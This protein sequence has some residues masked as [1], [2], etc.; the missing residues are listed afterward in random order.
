MP[1]IE[2]RIALSI[3][4]RHGEVSMIVTWHLWIHF[5]PSL[6]LHP[7]IMWY[8]LL[9]LH[10]IAMWRVLVVYGSTFLIV[11]WSIIVVLTINIQEISSSHMCLVILCVK[12]AG[13]LNSWTVI[14]SVI[15]TAWIHVSSWSCLHCL[16]AL[17]GWLLIHL[18]LLS[19]WIRRA[20]ICRLL[21]L[22]RCSVHSL[23]SV[24][25]LR[26][27]HGLLLIDVIIVWLPS[28]VLIL[29]SLEIGRSK[30]FWIT[31]DKRSLMCLVHYTFTFVLR[32]K[33]LKEFHFIF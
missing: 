11:H 6:R 1:W 21:L 8:V 14:I 2:I 9:S 15:L 20:S 19:D 13:L 12:H 18:I 26:V 30:L 22:H 29:I 23:S 3:R 31:V 25:I 10:F 32:D 17:F 16:L 7:H 27:K 5:I 4:W 33:W 28:P 24:H